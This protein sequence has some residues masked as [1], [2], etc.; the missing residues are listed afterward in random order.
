M[1]DTTKLDLSRENALRALAD[2]IERADCAPM[3]IDPV[4]GS[5]LRAL[6]DAKEAAE[7]ER[8]ECAAIVA[9]EEGRADKAQAQLTEARASA[10]AA[11]EAL[12][13]I[14]SDA[15]TPQQFYDRNGPTWTTPSGSE[16]ANMSEHLEKCNELAAKARSAIGSDPSATEALRRVKEAVWE[17]G[18]A[19]G[20]KLPIDHQSNPYAAKEAAHD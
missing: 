6:L 18:Y 7:R 11:W 14:A 17:E 5:A 3:R 1:T 8:D 15:E 4:A 9:I 19:A 2:R 10:A 16:Y 20:C 13:E 12:A